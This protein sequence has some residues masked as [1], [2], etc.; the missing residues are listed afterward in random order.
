MPK[1]NLSRGSLLAQYNPQDI[2]S[3]IYQNWESSKCFVAE[4]TSSKPP[5]SIT[6]PPPNVTG[7]LHLG[8]ALDQTLQDVFVRWKR[9]LGYNV[10]WVPGMD[11]AG[12]ATQ[13]IVEKKLHKEGQ[14]RQEL[15]REKFLEKVWEW[16]HTYGERILT[17]MKQLGFSCDWSRLCF[18]LDETVSQ[19]VNRVFV[20]LYH[21]GFIYRGTKLVNW[22]TQLKSALSNLEVEHRVVKGKLWHI[23]YPLVGEG[24]ELVVAT[25]RPETLIGDTAVAVHPKDVRYKNWEGKKVKLPL[26]DREIPIIMDKKISQEFGTGA[27]K[28]TPAHDFNDYEMGNKHT[29][30]VINILNPDGTLNEKA[31]VYQGLSMQEARKKVVNDLEEHGY[32]LKVENHTHSVGH[33]SRTGQVVEPLLSQQWF[34][35]MDQLSVHA[36][37]AVANGTTSFEPDL[38]AKTYLHWLD[39]IQDWCVS[40]QLWWGHRIPAWYCNECG[41][42]MVSEGTP[43]ECDQCQS[44]KIKQEE[45]VLDTWFSSALWPFSTLGWP[46]HTKLQ[47]TFYPND[48]LVT[49][50]DIIFFWVARMMMMG[51]YFKQDVPFRKVLVHGLVRDAQGDKMSKSKGNSLD[52]LELTQK[53]GADALR[54]TLSCLMMSGKDLKFSMQRLEGYRNFINKVWNAA[55]LLLSLKMPCQ[56]LSTERMNQELDKHR[57]HFSDFDLWIIGKLRIAVREANEHLEQYRVSD[58]AQV[59]YTFTWHQFCDWYLEML[60]T[61]VYD[62]SKDPVHKEASLFVASQVF[63]NILKL[64]HPFTPFVTEKLAKFYLKEKSFIMKESYPIFNTS[65]AGDI[66]IFSLDTQREEKELDF[67]KSVITAIRNIRGENHIKPSE[68]ILVYAEPKDEFAQK[69]L[70]TYSLIITKLSSLK[71]M[72][73]R[74]PE[75]LNKSAVSPVKSDNME[76]FVV[77]PLFGLVDFDEEK[78]RVQKQIEKMNKEFMS[79]SSRLSNKNFL[80]NAPTEVV[81]KQEKQKNQLQQK[82]EVLEENL[83]RL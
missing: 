4:E 5:F 47:S 40:R 73:V 28:I 48:L 17:Q 66:P 10:L 35:K 68:K 30:P 51:L 50:H 19:A 72:R 59:L 26:M 54:F 55:R 64:L 75:T 37:R 12:I 22:N 71:E 33:C 2:E 18:T 77:V 65:S 3:S 45:D 27:V 69:I 1:D 46:E 67:V 81:Q 53:Y 23:R 38:W 52:P 7:Q 11:H 56:V 57:K 82:I 44:Q 63:W 80:K 70:Q 79:L 83:S 20:Q 21:K 8:H 34:V 24:G 43:K 9:M 15:G 62:D 31:G 6:L 25:T 16:K 29:L 32:L 42:I 78:K 61:R 39:I 60:K 41:H 74:A 58:A 36:Q 76:V 13:T 49:G 14:S